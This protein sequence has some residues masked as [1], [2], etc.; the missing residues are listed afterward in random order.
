M[1][2]EEDNR[3]LT[4]TLNVRERLIDHLTKESLPTSSRDV[5]SLTNLLESVD[6]S[7]LD[8]AKLKIEE[9][10]SQVNKENKE[11]L[12]NLLLDLHSNKET[13]IPSANELPEYVPQ[14][15][16]INE[17]ELIRGE[18]SVSLNDVSYT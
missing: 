18:D 3:L 12:K 6:R 9:Q 8:K 1:F 16:T 10:D 4:K 15:I 13:H 11:I 17:G 5:D 7:I 14:G 2:T